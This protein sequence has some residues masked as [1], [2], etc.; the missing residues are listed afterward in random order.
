M[1]YCA[2]ALGKKGIECAVYGF[3]DIPAGSLCTRCRSLDDCLASCAAVILPMPLSKDDTNIA[4]SDIPIKLGDVFSKVP[5]EAPVFA[6]AVSEKI[7][8]AAK[9][10]NMEI[11]D[12]LDDEVLTEKNAYATAEG[13]LML[14]MKN[15]ERTIFGSEILVCGYGRIGRYTARI[16]KAIGANVTVYAR[17]NHP[18]AIAK[19]DGYST[20]GNN[21]LAEGIKK[22]THIINTVPAN[23]FTKDILSKTASTQVYIE[24]ASAP[25]GI[26]KKLASGH[27]M[28]I[29]DGSSLPSKYC[30][31]SA[32][33]YIAE[34]LL[35]EFER[36]GII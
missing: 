7:R 5:K 33:E 8:T 24:L 17:R 34:K 19:L 22:Y 30:P 11:C 10:Y 14:V 25:Y 13:A 6:G 9:S 36:S 15:S 18:L 32:G 20:V 26:D 35:L 21:N 23:I 29:V 1:F 3:N 12:F 28:E 2:E 16:L 4:V 27:N 31:E